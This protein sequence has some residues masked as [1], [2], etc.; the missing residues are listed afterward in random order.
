MKN[1]IEKFIN[2]DP[3]TPYPISRSHHDLLEDY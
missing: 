2:S 3:L 1:K